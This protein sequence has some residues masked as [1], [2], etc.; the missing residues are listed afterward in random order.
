M[1]KLRGMNYRSRKFRKVALPVH[2]FRRIPDLTPINVLLCQAYQ[3]DQDALDQL[4]TP[5]SHME[6]SE[7]QFH[8]NQAPPRDKVVE[9]A[10]ILIW[11]LQTDQEPPALLKVSVMEILQLS[12]PPK[13]QPA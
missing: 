7:Y 2:L 3:V 9:E 4:T 6:T 5:A 10:A 1:S 8:V 12:K 13:N 11:R